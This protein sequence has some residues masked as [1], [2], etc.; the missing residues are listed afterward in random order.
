MILFKRATTEKEIIFA[1]LV[2][3]SNDTLPFWIFGN[4]VEVPMTDESEDSNQEDTEWLQE[5]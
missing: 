3:E 1:F 2:K 5:V 4:N